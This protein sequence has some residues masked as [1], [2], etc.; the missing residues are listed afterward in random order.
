MGERIVVNGRELNFNDLPPEPK[1]EYT[2]DVDNFGEVSVTKG[3][4]P[5]H[6]SIVE[7]HE[8]ELGGDVKC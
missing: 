5:D 1:E 3:K 6:G 8:P 7:L 4:P 2:V